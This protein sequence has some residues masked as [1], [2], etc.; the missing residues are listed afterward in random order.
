MLTQPE[1]ASFSPKEKGYEKTER[2]IC[3]CSAARH[4]GRRRFG[5]STENSTYHGGGFLLLWSAVLSSWVA[6]PDSV[7]S[8][9]A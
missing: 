7:E 4:V 3:N 6:L 5:D 2:R 1:R 9:T 8:G